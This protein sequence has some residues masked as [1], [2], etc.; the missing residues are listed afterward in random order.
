MLSMGI[1]SFQYSPHRKVLLFSSGKNGAAFL[2][3]QKIL[4]SD[5]PG[6]QERGIVVETHL[7]NNE[8]K[9]TFTR[10]KALYT[11]FLFILIGKDGGEKLRSSQVV[12]TRQL[13]GLIDQM[14]MR[15]SEMK[16]QQK[17]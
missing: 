13:F 6:M 1:T 5:S 17:P 11:P 2:Q 10:Y 3:Q 15:R 12:T 8:N 4:R 9:A 14:P 7:L 16:K